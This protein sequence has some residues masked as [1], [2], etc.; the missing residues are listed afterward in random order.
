MRVQF[1]VVTVTNAT[2]YVWNISIAKTTISKLH[3]SELGDEKN[4]EKWD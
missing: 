2:K 3:L 1:L 4:D